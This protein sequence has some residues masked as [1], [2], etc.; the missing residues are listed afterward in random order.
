MENL[1]FRKSFPLRQKLRARNVL[2]VVLICRKGLFS[3][4]S[5]EPNNHNIKLIFKKDCSSMGEG[6]P[7]LRLTVRVL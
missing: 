2:T 6:S 5:A 3:A 4:E 1:R 7:F